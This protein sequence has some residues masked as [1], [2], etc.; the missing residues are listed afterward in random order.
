MCPH[1]KLGKA[2]TG[3]PQDSF[4]KQTEGATLSNIGPPVLRGHQETREEVE[5]ACQDQET[6][7]CPRNRD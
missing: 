7:R 2:H 5:E 1:H 3:L 4:D 6:G